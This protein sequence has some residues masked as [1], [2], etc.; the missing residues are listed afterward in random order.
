MTAGSQDNRPAASTDGARG[1]PREAAGGSARHGT[2]NSAD[3]THA[4]RLTAVL[5]R[6]AGQSGALAA[7]LADAGVATVDFPLIDI[8]PATDP[9]PLDAAFAALANYA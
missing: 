3:G 7:Q 5:T 6:P 2:R 4:K 9:A 1:A 8:A